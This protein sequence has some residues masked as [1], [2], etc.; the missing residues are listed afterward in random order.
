MVQGGVA[1]STES[2]VTGLATECLDLLSST[3]CAVSN[4]GVDVSVCDAEVRTLVV[5]T[6]EA[7]GIYPFWNTPSAF[8]LT[9]GAHRKRRRFHTRRESGGEAA[10]RTIKWGA[11]L[12]EMLDPDVDGSY[13]RVE[14]VLMEPGRLP[15]PQKSKP[16]LYGLLPMIENTVS[17]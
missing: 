12:E 6:G 4:Q 15:K 16:Q 3:M 5:G 14:R 17:S 2:G 1:S 11:W 13:S 9:P 8:D 10:G 7:L